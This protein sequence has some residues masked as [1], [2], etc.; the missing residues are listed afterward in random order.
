M[1]A[2]LSLAC[3][4][5]YRELV[6]KKTSRKYLRRTKRGAKAKPNPALQ[7]LRSQ[8]IEFPISED[9]LNVLNICTECTTGKEAES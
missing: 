9:I 3:K 2:H 7:Y 5:Y 8:P 6:G 4:V 1:C